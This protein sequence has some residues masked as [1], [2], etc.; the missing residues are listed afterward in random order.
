MNLSQF[1]LLCRDVTWFTGNKINIS[2]LQQGC[3]YSLYVWLYKG[4]RVCSGSRNCLAPPLSRFFS[5][6]TNKDSLAQ[7]GYA[8]WHSQPSHYTP[9]FPARDAENIPE[10]DWGMEFQELSRPNVAMVGEPTEEKKKN[11]QG[12]W[13]ESANK[14]R[15]G[16]VR[17]QEGQMSTRTREGLD[18]SARSRGRRKQVSLSLFITW[19]RCTSIRWIKTNL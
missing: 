16:C 11:L 18:S 8:S 3:K 10:A 5:S 6:S 19:E 1:R 12:Q 13:A 7:Q 2:H 17:R 9:P 4:N 15:K 14:G